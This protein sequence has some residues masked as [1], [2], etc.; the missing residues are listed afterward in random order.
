[1]DK[2]D[3]LLNKIPL[4]ANIFTAKTIVTGGVCARALESST[5]LKMGNIVPADG[6]DLKKHSLNDFVLINT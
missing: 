2:L 1:M 6:F 3:T 5:V 4:I